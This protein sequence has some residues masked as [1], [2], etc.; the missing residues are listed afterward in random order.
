[1]AAHAVDELYRGPGTDGCASETGVARDLGSAFDAVSGETDIAVS[2]DGTA[3]DSGG[4]CSK[5]SDGV[6]SM[7]SRSSDSLLDRCSIEASRLLS[8]QELQS[9][10]LRRDFGASNDVAVALAGLMSALSAVVVFGY[11]AAP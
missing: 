11:I 3:A 10:V 8:N 7:A 2:G 9:M 6:Q 4:A 1:M 5:T